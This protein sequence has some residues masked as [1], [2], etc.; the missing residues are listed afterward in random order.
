M[1]ILIVSASDCSFLVDSPQ[2]VNEVLM[3]LNQGQ[4]RSL[5]GRLLNLPNGDFSGVEAVHQSSFAEVEH[6]VYVD[7]VAHFLG[8]A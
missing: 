6:V 5:T 2:L 1:G 7:I 3:D 4:R 8:K